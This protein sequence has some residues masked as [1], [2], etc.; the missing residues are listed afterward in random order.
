[1]A[2]IVAFVVQ[3]L[4]Q[5]WSYKLVFATRYAAAVISVLFFF[6]LDRMFRQAEVTV[7]EGGSYFAFLLIGGTFSRY[8]EVGMRSFSQTLREEMLRGTIEPLL[9]TATSTPLVLLGPSIWLLIEG[10]L[11]ALVQLAMGTLLGADFSRANWPAA[12][13]VTLVSLSSL[14]SYGILSA[15]F[16]IVFKRADPVNWLIGLL[17]HVFSGVF[18][19]IT[20]LPPWLRVISYLLPFTY[21][22]NALRG[23]LMR[24][25]GL[26]Q[27]APDILVLLGFTAVLL[28]IALWSLRV[29][30]QHLKRTGEL[31]HY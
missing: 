6:F 19:P 29:A 3:G 10:T 30:I 26:A 13:F 17:V 28:P 8:L 31:G 1:M 12:I 25:S 5:A 22:L 24:G 15:A 21:A 2:K 27:L 14:L 16:T 20:I 11:L 23:A 18:F 7:V 4:A 9:V